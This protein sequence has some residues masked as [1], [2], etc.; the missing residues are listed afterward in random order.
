MRA[1]ILIFALVLTAATDAGAELIISHN[2]TEP[3]KNVIMPHRWLQHHV[4]KIYTPDRYS[5]S[6]RKN[7]KFCVDRRGNPLNGKIVNMYDGFIAYENYAGGYQHGITSVFT[8]D[9]NLHQR[10]SYKK[11]LK[12][13]TEFI[14]YENGNVE[15]RLSYNDGELDGRIE[16]YSINGVLLGKFNYKKGYLRD[17]YCKNEEEGASMKER[18]KKEHYNQILPC[19]TLHT[20]NN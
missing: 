13:G 11:G 18:L 10:S 20:D 5:C 7:L 6:L 3:A 2:I 1:K 9:G 17:G 15:F 14:Y 19:G 16:Q 4:D 12:E 8:G